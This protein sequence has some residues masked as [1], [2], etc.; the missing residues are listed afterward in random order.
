MVWSGFC[1]CWIYILSHVTSHHL[2][3]LIRFNFF[4]VQ[5]QLFYILD[6]WILVL[7]YAVMFFLGWLEWLTIFN[8]RTSLL[9][10]CNGLTTLHCHCSSGISLVR[11]PGT[12]AC[13]GCGQP[14]PIFNI[15][16][17]YIVCWILSKCLVNLKCKL[18]I[19]V[20][21]CLSWFL[22]ILI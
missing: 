12:S 21:M 22:K 1:G 4:T 6:S 11:G 16:I 7:C 3:G 19:K 17:Y 20:Q 15:K 10:S 13:Y 2:F 8:I 14:P 5:N 9:A 18:E